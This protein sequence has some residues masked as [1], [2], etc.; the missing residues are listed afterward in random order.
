MIETMSQADDEMVELFRQ[1]W[2]VAAG[3]PAVYPNTNAGIPKAATWAHWGISYTGGGQ[4]TFGAP[5][6][7]KFYQEGAILITVFSPLGVGSRA[8]R[9]K[10]AIALS[11]YEGKR[12]PGGVVFA[13]CHIETEG[14]GTV[15]GNN[16]VWWATAVVA[17]F[18]YEYLR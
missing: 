14:E 2:Q 17:E 6:R 16:G 11:A 10:A 4:L 9:E 13:N 7:R 18:N 5:G 12:T 15:D 1:T 3:L 8:G